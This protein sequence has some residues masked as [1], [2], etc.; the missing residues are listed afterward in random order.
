MTEPLLMRDAGLKAGTPARPDREGWHRVAAGVY[1][2]WESWEAASARER[3]MTLIEAAVAKYSDELVLT[4]ASAALASGIP[5]VGRVPDRVQCV[6]GTGQRKRTTLV[7]RSE[8]ALEAGD[9]VVIDG[10]AMTR[11]EVTAIDLARTGGLV[12]GV[13]AMDWMLHESRVEQAGLEEAVER[14]PRRARGRA[15]A[16]TAV[17]LAD[18][19]SESPGESLS[20]VRMWQA[21]LPRPDRQAT[22]APGGRERRVDFLWP[23]AAVFGEHDGRVKYSASSFGRNPEDVMRDEYERDLELRRLGLTP[24]HWGWKDAWHGEGGRMLDVLARVGVAPI[25]RRW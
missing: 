3:H 25:G 16:R 18:G 12:P 21:G 14:L 10:H 22:F 24:A 20:R 11:P 13:V 6:G 4:S 5:F 15:A 1:V 8:R 9:V 23:E 17:R 2:P 7:A 19:L